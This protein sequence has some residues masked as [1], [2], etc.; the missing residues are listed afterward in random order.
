MK[1][2][3]ELRV[4]RYN[5]KADFTQSLFLIE[6]VFNCY[7]I[8]DEERTV[9]VWG[10]TC[11]P[12]GRYKV[13]LRTEGKFHEQYKVKFPGFHVGM[14]HVTNVPGFEYILIHIGNDDDDTAG[15]YLPGMDVEAM[16]VEE[17]T[18]AYEK[19][20]KQIAPLLVAGDDVYIT[21]EK[22]AA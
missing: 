5:S 19:I 3:H 15:C 17:S 10:E 9:K 13:E 14:L 21:Y 4:L 6:N 18:K 12:L 7:G 22:I 8:E 11:I 1:K 16:T 2:T 20:Y